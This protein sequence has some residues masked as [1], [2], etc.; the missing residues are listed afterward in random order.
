MVHHGRC[1]P[2]K[3]GSHD[4]GQSLNGFV[5]HDSDVMPAARIFFQLIADFVVYLGLLVRPI[6]RSLDRAKSLATPSQ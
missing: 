5:W 2:Q 6:E 3:I 4:F 1:P